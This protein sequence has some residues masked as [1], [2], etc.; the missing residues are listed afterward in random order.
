MNSLQYDSN[1][2]FQTDSCL[3]LVDIQWKLAY[4]FSTYVHCFKGPGVQIAPCTWL[5]CGLAAAVRG[6][7]F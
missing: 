4:T 5:S 6:N 7:A 3:K 2:W 1:T